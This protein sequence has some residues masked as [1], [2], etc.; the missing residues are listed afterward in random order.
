MNQRAGRPTQA[1]FIV[2]P[3]RGA[4]R[5]FSSSAR[6]LRAHAAKAN[7][8]AQKREAMCISTKIANESNSKTLSFR[9]GNSSKRGFDA[10]LRKTV[11]RVYYSLPE[12]TSKP[13]QAQARPK[14]R[15]MHLK[16]KDVPTIGTCC[17]FLKPIK[18]HM[19]KT[20]SVLDTGTSG[21]TPI[22]YHD[23]PWPSAASG[24][25]GLLEP[26][27]ASIAGRYCSCCCLC[28]P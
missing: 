24:T 11:K 9:T 3:R 10:R 16:R 13:D 19:S 22:G 20:G 14:Q 8:P 12:V 15:G 6:W 1:E 5:V 17:F 21:S 27:S 4:P 23:L 25:P 26:A 2:F 28:R 7:R 18:K